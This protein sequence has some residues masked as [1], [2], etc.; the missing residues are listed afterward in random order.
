MTFTSSVSCSDEGEKH[1]VSYGIPPQ[2]TY[3]ERSASWSFAF[4]FSTRTVVRPMA[5]LPMMWMPSH[6]K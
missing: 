1:L 4:M 3:E 5:V 6:A 2:L